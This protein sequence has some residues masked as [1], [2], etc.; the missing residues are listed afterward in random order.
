MSESN[1]HVLVES[2]G[3]EVFAQLLSNSDPDI[4]FYCA[5]ALSNLAVHGKS[6]RGGVSFLWLRALWLVCVCVCV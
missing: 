2:G 1:R 4:Q 6:G 3:V 5:A